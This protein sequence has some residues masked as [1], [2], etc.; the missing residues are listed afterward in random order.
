[1]QS[2][3]LIENQSLILQ[4]KDGYWKGI[5]IPT[6]FY[7]ILEHKYWVILNLLVYR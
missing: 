6:Y 3:L 1:M 4:Y 2:D 5:F 7:K